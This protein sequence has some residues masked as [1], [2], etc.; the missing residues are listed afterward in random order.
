MPNPICTLISPSAYTFEF[1][2]IQTVL[3]FQLL[4]TPEGLLSITGPVVSIPLRS[5]NG[6]DCLESSPI[7][8]GEPQ[9]PDSRIFNMLVS[10][11]F[12]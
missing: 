10:F 5:D 1:A 7:E 12:R 4:G 9:M 8:F 2:G 11:D 3:H 6:G